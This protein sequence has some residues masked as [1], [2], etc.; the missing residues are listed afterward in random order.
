MKALSSR[1]TVG[2]MRMPGKSFL[3]ADVGM[4]SLIVD[5]INIL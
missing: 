4:D 5:N 1:A 2:R 3:N